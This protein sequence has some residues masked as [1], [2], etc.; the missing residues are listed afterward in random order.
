VSDISQIY[1]NLEEDLNFCLAVVSDG[2]SYSDDLFPKAI[3]VL[4]KIHKP[5]IMIDSMQTLHIKNQVN[6]SKCTNL[7]VENQLNLTIIKIED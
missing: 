4:R 6:L 7:F 2:R 5:V 3:N 1:L